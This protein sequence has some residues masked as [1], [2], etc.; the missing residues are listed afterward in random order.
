[1]FVVSFLVISHLRIQSANIHNASFLLGGPPILPGYF[2][3][4]ALSRK[5]NFQVDGVA[6]IHHQMNPQGQFF[7]GVFS[8]QQ[9]RGAAFTFDANRGRDYSSKN[10][11]AL[12]L[13]PVATADLSVTLLISCE[14]LRSIEGVETFLHSA[15][16]SGGLVVDNG[17]PE[18]FSSIEEAVNSIGNGFAVLDRRDLLEPREG[19]NQAELFIE[20]LGARSHA[21][22]DLSWMSATCLGYA[23]ISAFE[24]RAGA[25]EGYQHVFA[26][27]LVG[28]VQYRSLRA[29][30]DLNILWRPE[31]ISGDVFRVCQ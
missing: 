16:F 13:Q 26:E 14:G 11:H 7:Y 19:R 10:P 28:L 9:R 31:W 21:D 12:S 17:S 6:M 8:P 24:D 25:R 3:A 20:A 4:H 1:V 29:C 22:V 15:K 2:F 27:P 23:G 5:L 18:I 30:V